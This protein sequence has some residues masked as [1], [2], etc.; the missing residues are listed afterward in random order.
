MKRDELDE[1]DKR[2]ELNG[3]DGVMPHRLSRRGWKALQQGI[4]IPLSL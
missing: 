3:K 2:D 1:H 4:A